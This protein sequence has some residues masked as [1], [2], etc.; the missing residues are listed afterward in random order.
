M[1]IRD[2]YNNAQGILKT[3]DSIASQTYPNIQHVIVDGASIDGSKEILQDYNFVNVIKISEPDSGIY[4]A[5][6]KGIKK[7][8]GDYLLFLNSGDTLRSNDVIETVV[9]TLTGG[10]DLYYGDLMMQFEEG[11]RIRKY[12]DILS[13]YYFFHKGSLPHPSLFFKK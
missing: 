12:P 10:K 11:D 6:N 8:S 7:A 9:P 1:C 13:F 4:N 5:M 2:S 3:L